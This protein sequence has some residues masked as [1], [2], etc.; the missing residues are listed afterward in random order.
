MFLTRRTLLASLAATALPVPSAFAEAEPF[1]VK[2]SDAKLIEYKFRRREVDY[3]TSEPP[4]TIVVEPRK[5]FLFH[6]L[7]GGKAMRYGASVGKAGRTWAGAATIGKKAKWPTWT[8][9]PEHLAEFPKLVKWKDGMP[10]GLDNPMGARALYL[11]QGEV[12]TIY[13][14]HGTHDPKLIGKKATAGC[15]GLLNSDIIHLYDRVDLGARVV[16]HA[17]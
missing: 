5:R 15:F 3:E 2:E 17:Y 12:D 1:R 7:G 9:T 10:G 13:R 4:G 14:I 11:Y 6:V 16:V 8:P